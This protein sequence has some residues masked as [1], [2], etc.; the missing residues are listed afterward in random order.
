MARLEPNVQAYIVQRL[1]CFD[2]PKQIADA[3]LD[4]FGVTIIRQRV[5]DYDPAKRPKLAKKWVAMHAAMRSAFLEETAKEPA[6]HRAVRVRRLGRMAERAEQKGNAVFAASLYEQ[7]AKEVGDSYTN[8]RDVHA[9][10]GGS[11]DVQVT[12]RIVRP[13]P[14]P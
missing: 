3:V 6:A 7:I 8:K 14:S 9:K 4:A 1:A 2:S 11:L 13:D 10:L 5:E 12:R